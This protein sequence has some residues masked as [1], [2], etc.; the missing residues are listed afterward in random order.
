MSCDV[1]LN[2]TASATSRFRILALPQGVVR[3]ESP[4]AS[5]LE[6]LFRWAPGRVSQ[7]TIKRLNRVR[8]GLT[9]SP[10]WVPRGLNLVGVTPEEVRSLVSNPLTP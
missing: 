7:G 5:F 2:G 6:S 9:N 1:G 10:T 8:K 4:P 3:L